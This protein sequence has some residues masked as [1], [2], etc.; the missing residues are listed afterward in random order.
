VIT[1]GW[2]PRSIYIAGMRGPRKGL[3]YVRKR[4]RANAHA[5]AQAMKLHAALTPQERE[6]L[7]SAG[8]S[9]ELPAARVRTRG[10]SAASVIDGLVAWLAAQGKWLRPRAIPAI[11]AFAALVAMIA[12]TSYLARGGQLKVRPRAANAA[13]A[14]EWRRIALVRP[15]PATTIPAPQVIVDW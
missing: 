6:L 5:R 12:S 8:S 7:A 1:P 4:K 3:A 9:A 10:V 11:A 14:W 2:M 13:Y 15:P